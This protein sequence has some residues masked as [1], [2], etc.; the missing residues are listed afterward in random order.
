MLTGFVELY[1]CN[2][3]RSSALTHANQRIRVHCG[4]MFCGG[5]T[6]M[7]AG[8]RQC[9][10]AN[11]HMYSSCSLHTSRNMFVTLWVGFFRHLGGSNLVYALFLCD[12]T[13]AYCFAPDGY[14]IFNVRTHLVTCRTDE[15]GFVQ[16]RASSD[17]SVSQNM[18]FSRHQLMPQYL[19][20]R[21]NCSRQTLTKYCLWQLFVWN[22]GP[23]FEG[24]VIKS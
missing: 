17:P 5:E 14:G 4:C 2:F 21:T 12:P 16:A 3:P 11:V 8:Q 15:G 18:V 1:V 24:T 6:V 13:T 7:Q 20:K 23:V 9:E 10:Y 19:Q 22:S